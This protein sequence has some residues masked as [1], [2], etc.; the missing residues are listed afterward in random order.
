MENQIYYSINDVCIVGMGAILPGANNINQFWQNIVTGRCA[1]RE[2]PNSRWKK[3]LYY[4]NE[5][6][7]DDKTTSNLAGYVDDDV[8]NDLAKDLNLSYFKTNRLT[9]MTLAAANQA[10][11]G[12]DLSK[13]SNK[14]IDIYLGCM[15]ADEKMSWQ[16]FMHEERESL[17]Q[18][19][20]QNFPQNHDTLF[21]TINQYFKIFENDQETM[22]SNLFTSSVLHH[23]K[24]RFGFRGKAGLIDAACASS[25]AAFDISMQVLKS[26]RADMV[27]TGGIESNL[28]VETFVLFE[29]VNALNNGICRPFDKSTKGLNQ[30]EGA[31]IF[32]LERLEDAL[33]YGH[34]IFGILKSCG[35]SSD[36]CS[37]SLFQ[38]SVAGQIRAYTN[39]YLDINLDHVDYIEAHGTGTPVGDGTELNSIIQFFCDRKIPI[40]SVK[41]MVGHTKGAAGA[42]SLLKCI[43][44]MKNRLI[45]PS[46]YFQES[47]IDAS[48]QA[49]VNT[50]PL[51][52]KPKASPLC[53]GISSFGFGGIN[54]H[55]VLQE[56]YSSFLSKQAAVPQSN[57]VVV[58]GYKNLLKSNILSSQSLAYFNIPP[59]SRAQIDL[60]QLG[61]LIIVGELI[62]ELHIN[63]HKLDKRS[64]SVI[65]SSTLGL[66][67][68]LAFSHRIQHFELIEALKGYDSK[69]IGTIINHKK[70]HPE[71]TE[72]IG[73]GILNNV[74]AGRV[75]NYFNLWGSNFNIDADFN[76]FPL[77]LDFAKLMLSKQDGLIILLAAEEIFDKSAMRIERKGISCFLLASLKYAKANYLP[78]QYEIDEIIYEEKDATYNE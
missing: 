50:K 13:I 9:L 65:S 41:A 26:Y 43:L 78:I 35:F 55:L 48:H 31:V 75:A 24:T 23:M 10:I 25:L 36:G 5:Q 42:V 2:I 64:I 12:I 60:L 19:I 47:L 16:Q 3:H 67:A 34:P 30:G 62:D 28:S 18:Y 38:P 45:P 15:D 32:L 70:K 63:I 1:I 21:D 29:K 40:G 27:I 68:S 77:A 69:V 17:K 54:Y 4:S 58:L 52:L 11:K 71:A 22:T 72:D 74:I 59:R 8:I 7:I 14:K 66:E 39:A 49:Y 73:P 51:D 76:S 56:Y 37:V 33:K 53:F 57:T 44:S 61:A 20:K 6:G 46:T